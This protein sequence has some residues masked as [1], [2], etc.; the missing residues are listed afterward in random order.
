MKQT[1]KK[2]FTLIEILIVMVLI[3]FLMSMLMVMMGNS[4]LAKKKLSVVDEMNKLNKAMGLYQSTYGAIPFSLTSLIG[5]TTSTCNSKSKK[6]TS[7]ETFY[8]PTAPLESEDDTNCGISKVSADDAALLPEETISTGAD[9]GKKIV[10]GT[11]DSTTNVI[12]L[13][14]DEGAGALDDSILIGLGTAKV[15]GLAADGSKET[16]YVGVWAGT[17][18]P[19]KAN[20]VKEVYAKLANKSILDVDGGQVSGKAFFYADQYDS[21]I[22]KDFIFVPQKKV[23]CTQYSPS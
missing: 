3:A 17:T 23:S 18:D 5:S 7:A 22:S 6:V 12:N 1:M 4:D 11:H 14:K 19:D 16:C 9:N 8:T 13:Y 20:I 21:T 2:G 10:I 15:T